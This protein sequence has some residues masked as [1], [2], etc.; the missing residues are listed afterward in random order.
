MAQR[1]IRFGIKNNSKRAATWKLWTETG[2]GKSEIYLANR[3][4]GGTLKASMHQSGRW[5]IAYTKEVYESRVKGTNTKLNDRFIEKW[6]MP[7]EI[8]PG[9]TLAFRIVTPF[10]AVTDST[11][12]GNYKGVKWLSNAPESKATEIDILIT[13]PNSLGVE[14]PGKNTMG[15]SLIG[16]FP[17][18]NSSTVWAVYWLI[19]MPNLS[20]IEKGTF[21]FF[22]G[23]NKE[24]L[25]SDGLRL[26]AFG[27]EP[28]GSR[29]LYDCAVKN[30]SANQSLHGTR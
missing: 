8:A 30:I 15:T 25:K 21:Q 6:S 24:D 12:K 23:K 20:K 18:E 19:N 22:A 16:S 1:S 28:D 2:G 13:K 11:E 26:I 29:V 7:P 27:K 4:L 17:L 10:S 14:W 9:I 3:S 5:H